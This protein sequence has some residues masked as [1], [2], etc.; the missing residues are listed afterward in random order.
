MTDPRLRPLLLLL[1]CWW[2]LEGVGHAAR[3]LGGWDQWDIEVGGK[4]HPSVRRV[5]AEMDAFA[6]RHG[7]VRHPEQEFNGN[8]HTLRTL[9]PSTSFAARL[10]NPS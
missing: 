4:G 10:R 9:L 8:Y 3:F 5:L 6:V 2:L 1:A 7:F